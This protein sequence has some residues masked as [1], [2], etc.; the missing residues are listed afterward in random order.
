PPPQGTQQCLNVVPQQGDTFVVEVQQPSG[1]NYK[2]TYVPAVL[3]PAFT[4]VGQCGTLTF[5]DQSTIT[6]ASSSITGW[7]WSFPGGTPSTANTPTA[8]VT[9]GSAG[10]YTVTLTVT[11]SAGCTAV[12]TQ[13]VNVTGLPQAAF[14]Y[15]PVCV[16]NATQFQDAS[17]AAAGDPLVAWNWTFPNAN[18][19]TSNQQH[20]TITFNTAGIYQCTLLVT[21]QQGCTAQVV[22]PVVVYNNPIADFID[23]LSGCR[24]VCGNFTDLSQPV[25]GQIINWQ[26]SFPGGSPSSSTAQN[27]QNICYNTPGSY[28]VTLIVTTNY[29]CK[30]TLT[31]NNYVNVYAWPN[32]DFSISP[33]TEQLVDESTFFFYNQWS[34]DVVSWVWDFG[35]G[36]PLDS[37][38]ANPAHSYSAVATN[39]TF[40]EFQICLRVEN[41]HG[42][43]DTI[44]KTVKL[45]PYFTFYIPNTFTP[46]DDKYND[47]FFGKSRGVKEYQIWIF[48]RWGN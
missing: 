19:A 4:Y 24:P 2:L 43:W 16:G 6:P 10:T 47:F 41:Q 34:S 26:W 11:S 13:T 21:S 8:T 36:S 46:N 14:T 32:A 30:D 39:N 5:T 38:N 45:L 23:S 40:Y 44:C 9:Y 7:S 31:I 25:D 28:P 17:V 3:Q 12:I 33:S 37:T 22:Q 1:C 27:P 48:D 35:D 18:P 29:G 15:T 42:C 20:P